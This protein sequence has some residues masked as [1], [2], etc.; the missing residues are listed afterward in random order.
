MF[1]R[2]DAEGGAYYN[3]KLA[4]V[5]QIHGSEI[6]VTFRD[7]GMDYTLHR[8]VWENVGYGFDEESGAVVR[9]QLGTFSQYPL[10]LA[11]AIT[12]HKSQGLTFD[13]VII[14]AGRSF[15]PGQVYVALSRCRSLEGIVLH[16]M[17]A[18]NVLLEDSR[19]VEFS[20]SH[21]ATGELQSVLARERTRYAHHLLIRLFTFAELSAHLDEWRELIV[22]KK[23]P[24]A[25]AAIALHDRIRAHTREIDAVAEK[26]R[27]QLDRLSAAAERDARSAGTLKERCRKAIG[28]F[29]EQIA[30][31]VAAP[32]REH[33]GA[34]GQKKKMKRYMSHV[35][36]IEDSCW[37][38]IDRL[39]GARYLD[40]R[41]YAGEAAYAR[42]T[43]TR[44]TASS[45][46]GHEE[47]GS[48]YNETLDLHRQGK[49]VDEIAAIRGLSV[50][51][52]KG[53]LARWI[54]SG[55]IDVYEVL[56]PETIGP[57]LAFL[58]QNE[59]PTVS[60]IRRGTGDIFDY[61]NIRMIVAHSSRGLAAQAPV[62]AHNL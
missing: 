62:S 33:L 2:N 51:T 20:A 54:A 16:S 41:L 26:F 8:E 28:Y 23:I 6:T 10:R 7:S 34:L 21:H 59:H 45:A 49:T 27:R 53:H 1:I 14:D 11:W 15:A 52:I 56:P 61:N 13:K 22:E 44:A 35:R 5:K 46:C 36:L 19:T 29:T 18:P 40:E 58:Q 3:G 57:V 12:I 39:Y 50:G 4:T 42:V 9:Q 24:D 55:D 17:I 37:S 30:T 31:R 47:K 43:Q 60:A 38:K 48:T 25:A 32:L